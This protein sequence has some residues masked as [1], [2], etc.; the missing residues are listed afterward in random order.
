MERQLET[1]EDVYKALAGQGQLEWIGESRTAA[2]LYFQ[3]GKKQFKVF[4]DDS[5]VEVSV[6]KRW[7]KDEYWDSLGTRHYDAP[8][9]TVNDVFD[10]VMWCLEEFGGRGKKD[11]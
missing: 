11:V 2:V 7:F 6:K 1:V 10:T 8:E 9:D 5:N 3:R 4:F